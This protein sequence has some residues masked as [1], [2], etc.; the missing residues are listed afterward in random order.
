MQQQFKELI[1]VCDKI[2]NKYYNKYNK[3]YYRPNSIGINDLKQECYISAFK[4]LKKFEGLDICS[5]QKL[6][7][8]SSH[9]TLRKIRDKCI[10]VNSCINSRITVHGRNVNYE[11][12]TCYQNH[13]DFYF[14]YLIK[15]LKK[16]YQNIL[17]MYYIKNKSFQDIANKKK[18]SKIT[19]YKK[20]KRA[21][22]ILRE[23]PNELI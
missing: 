18:V 20:F 8:Q 2:A 6:T 13:E 19:I 11:P 16:T 21:I 22:E 17:W 9:W 4:V 5:L 3:Y 7:N 12:W 15:N 14:K 10:K 23:N 1:P